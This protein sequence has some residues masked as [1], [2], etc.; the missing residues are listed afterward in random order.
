MTAVIRRVIHLKHR[1]YYYHSSFLFHRSIN[2]N[3]IKQKATLANDEAKPNY[4]I[5]D[6]KNVHLLMERQ[7]A[8]FNVEELTQFMFG[9][10][11]NYFEINT[12]R[13]IS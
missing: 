6:T 8:T 11:E 5:N 12:R 13:Q 7:S 9:G 10:L 3:E 1:I 4:E 2:F